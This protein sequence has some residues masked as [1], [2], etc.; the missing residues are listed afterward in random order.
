MLFFLVQFSWSAWIPVGWIQFSIFLL[1]D[2]DMHSAYTCYGNV[3][4]WRL[5][6]CQTPVLYQNG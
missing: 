6:V 1:R 5:A 2:A 3:A 4:G